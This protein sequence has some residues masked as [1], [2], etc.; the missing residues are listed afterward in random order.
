MKAQTLVGDRTFRFG[1][2]SAERFGAGLVQAPHTE[3]HYKRQKKH[4]DS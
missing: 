2:G 4:F 3:P 1:A